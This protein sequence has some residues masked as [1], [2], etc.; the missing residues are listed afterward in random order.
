MRRATDTTTDEVTPRRGA[1]GPAVSAPPIPGAEADPRPRFADIY[2]AYFAFVWRSALRLGTPRV[3][4][5]DVVQEIFIVANN[6]LASFEG[7]S[8]VQTWLFGIVL[9]VVRTHRRTLAARQPH[10]L[11]ADAQTDP[12]TLADPAD[13]PHE[14]AARAE[15]ARILDLVLDALDDSKREVFVLAEL[16]QMSAPEIG[17][18]LSLPINTVYSRLRHARRQFA[19]AAARYRAQHQRRTQWTT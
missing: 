3:T 9:N 4:I 18:A 2:E 5:D 10:L 1:I 12:E 8:S 6:R 19:Q 17:A 11:H 15:D 7:R 16:E 13:G 14:R